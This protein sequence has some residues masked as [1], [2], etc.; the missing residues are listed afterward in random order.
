MVRV[1][2][3][4]NLERH[5]QC[6]DVEVTG[7]TVREALDAVLL[8]HPAITGYILDDQRAVR[9]HVVVFIDGEPIRDRRS[10]SD[11]VRPNSEIFVMQAL[12]GG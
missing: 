5:V 2:F 8:Q 11:A 9:D 1:A 7:A 10:L 12:S 4:K 3:T 6:P